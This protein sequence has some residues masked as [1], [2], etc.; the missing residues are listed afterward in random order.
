MKTY[1][2]LLRFMSAILVRSSKPSVTRFAWIRQTGFRFVKSIVQIQKI[3]NRF[4]TG[5]TNR[6][7]PLSAHSRVTTTM[8]VFSLFTITSNITWGHK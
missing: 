7:R 1:T 2:N 3:Q 6:L 5:L 4:R 8:F